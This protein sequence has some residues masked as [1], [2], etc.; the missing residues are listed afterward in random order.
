M[1]QRAKEHAARDIDRELRDLVGNY[2]ELKH[3][4]QDIRA[5][6]GAAEQELA[7]FDTQQGQQMNKLEGVSKDTAAAWKW[8]QDNLNDFE[9]EVYGPPMISCSVKDSKYTDAVESLLRRGDFLC[10]TA[11]T[12]S[13]LKKL[14]NQFYGEMR[15][16]DITLRTNEESI[17]EEP[18]DLSSEEMQR[19]G[20][21]GWAIDF[22]DGP[23]PVLGM[24]CDSARL[25]K[26]AVTL[27]DITEEQYNLII[28][29]KKLN[30]WTTGMHSY[31]VARRSEYG[32]LAVS[33]T[34]KAI[35]RAEYWT[36]RPVDTSVRRDLERSINELTTAFNEL[37]GQADL[38]KQKKADM[39]N[40]A[41]EITQEIV[42]QTLLH[43]G[44]AANSIAPSREN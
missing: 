5:K 1:A 23:G 15:L 18:R 26:S 41:K 21:E 20:M 14:S 28:Q 44:S 38:F 7:S 31:N 8:I 39:E 3:S 35:K 43:L 32:P 25:Q 40:R 13:D 34:T 6:K 10:I 2:E 42:S 16:T 12:S 24:L 36:D 37:K 11:Q 22:L 9:E 4:G 30:R 33:T 29:E 19:Y 17:L 27:R